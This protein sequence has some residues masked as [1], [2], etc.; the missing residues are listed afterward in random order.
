MASLP[1]GPR[2]PVTSIPARVPGSVRR[3]TNIDQHRGER[4]EVLAQGRDLQT[5]TDGTTTVL[6]EVRLHLELD[7]S[8][9]ITA[10][11]SDPVEPA[12]AKLV[13]LNNQRGFRAAMDEAV[14]HHR[15]ATT[16]LHQLL[17][18][19]P[20]AALINGYGWTREL[21]DDFDLPAESSD[22]LRDRCAG[23]INDGVMLGALDET[24]IFPIPLGP[25]APDLDHPDDPLAWHDM[26]PMAPQSVRRRRR[27]DVIGGDPLRV[28][29]HFRDSHLALDA[30]EDVLHEYTLQATV[31]PGALV[32]LSA[33]AQA[34]TL[35]WPECPNALAS[36]TRLA[37]EPV[38]GLRSKVHADFRGTTTCTHLNDVLR[39]LAGV[40]ALAKGL[41]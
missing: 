16:V 12:L 2:D 15:E 25:D 37:D 32:V 24:G 5:A 20:M 29:V 41:G 8:G 3:S 36:A 26:D 22:R 38:A 4:F 17:D 19:V 9:T 7:V 33:E 30:A 34:R 23:W 31:D 18:D 40:A 14:P 6:D 11:E 35:P 28:D 1:H 39:S 21:G 13:G 10:I 27:L